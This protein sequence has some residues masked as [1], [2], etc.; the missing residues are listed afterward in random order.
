MALEE[1]RPVAIR[2]KRGTMRY[3]L[4]YLVLIAPLLLA[5]AAAALTLLFRATASR[6]LT[7][8]ASPVSILAVGR[9]Q[10]NTNIAG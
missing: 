9:R 6:I 2:G 8:E 1:K 10:N 5:A 3:L 7:G 4:L